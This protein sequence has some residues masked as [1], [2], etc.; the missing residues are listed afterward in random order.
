MAYM[1]EAVLCWRSF[2][3][4]REGP[5]LVLWTLIQEEDREDKHGTV[6]RT[7]MLLQG[8]GVYGAR[9]SGLTLCS[10]VLVCELG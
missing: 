1:G 3:L 10:V 2:R 9:S 5:L 4:M 8:A 7:H 6:P